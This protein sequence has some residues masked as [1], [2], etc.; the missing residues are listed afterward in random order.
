LEIYFLAVKFRPKRP[1]DHEYKHDYI[2]TILIHDISTRIQKTILM[3][4]TS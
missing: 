2:N 4:F 3:C 1:Y